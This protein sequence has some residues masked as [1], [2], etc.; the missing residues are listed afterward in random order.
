MVLCRATERTFGSSG[1][2]RGPGPASGRSSDSSGSYPQ[3][4]TVRRK[5]PH[6]TTFPRRATE[7]L[8]CR[9]PL[10]A[11]VHHAVE[12]SDYTLSMKLSTW[13]V[14]CSGFFDSIGLYDRPSRTQEQ[15]A[16]EW[17]NRFGLTDLV[18]PP[19]MESRMVSRRC[20]RVRSGLGLVVVV[21]CGCVHGVALSTGAWDSD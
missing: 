17:V 3:N 21:V 15:I 10:C 11:V 5:H 1:G 16:R 6:H 8:H 20:R 18:K 12:Y 19:S 13:D 9:E 7:A 4:F 2:R 14:I